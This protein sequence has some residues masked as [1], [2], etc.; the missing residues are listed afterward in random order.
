MHIL[1][2]NTKHFQ[3]YTHRHLSCWFWFGL[4]LWDHPHQPITGGIYSSAGWLE[5]ADR[6]QRLSGCVPLQN[7]ERFQNFIEK[8]TN[9]TN[10]VCKIQHWSLERH[11]NSDS[12]PITIVRLLSASVSPKVKKCDV[13]INKK[14]KKKSMQTSVRQ[15]S[16]EPKSSR[17]RWAHLWLSCWRYWKR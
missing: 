10:Q 6:S 11:L 3:E 4:D 13:G 5:K 2:L 14:R 16:S 12:M 8:C 7:T 9:T 1:V 17:R 15:M